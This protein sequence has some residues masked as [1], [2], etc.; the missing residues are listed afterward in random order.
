MDVIRRYA[1]D[2]AK[3]IGFA[4][5]N[6]APTSDEDKKQL[7]KLEIKAE[8]DPK[9]Y[10]EISDFVEKM[11]EFGG[12]AGTLDKTI[13]ELKDFAMQR[14][15]EFESDEELKTA[16]KLRQEDKLTMSPAVQQLLQS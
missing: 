15:R 11:L 10:A 8:V 12:K 2:I 3:Q 14:Q 9:V 16:M 5:Q 4:A 7:A 6:M 1:L 13:R